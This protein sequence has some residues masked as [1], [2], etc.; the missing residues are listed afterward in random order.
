MRGMARQP[1]RSG[2]G[3]GIRVA[4]QI[5]H[6]LAELIRAEVKDP[7]IGMVTLTG[8]DLTPDYAH[9]TVHYTVL[10]DDDDTVAATQAGLQRA[11]G[12][13]RAQIGRRVRIHTTPELRFRIDRSI[14]R[15]IEL[16]KLIEAANRKH[17][18]D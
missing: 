18:D 10:P 6:E 9:A 7:R 15:G 3:R 13:L 5:H 4:E 2:G 8:V 17:A 1:T 16:T 12:F 14:E 11:A